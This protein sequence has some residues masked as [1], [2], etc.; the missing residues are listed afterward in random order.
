MPHIQKRRATPL[1]IASDDTISFFDEADDED[2]G[3]MSASTNKTRRISQKD[4]AA[5][6]ASELHSA[7]MKARQ[8]YVKDCEIGCG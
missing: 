5:E 4:A 3:P 6:L 8:P 7:L 1:R 2:W